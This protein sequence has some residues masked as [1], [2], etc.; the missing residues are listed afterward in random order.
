MNPTQNQDNQVPDTRPTGQDGIP[1]AGFEVWLRQ[2]AE[3]VSGPVAIEPEPF[4][5]A[6]AEVG[7]TV[8]YAGLRALAQAVAAAP[9][10]VAQVL[11][12]AALYLERH[13]WTQHV[14]YDPTATIFTPAADMVGAIAMVC[15]GGPCE[16]PAQ[17]FD[18]PG[19]LDFEQAVLH[20]D[21]FLLVEYGSQAYEFND[22]PGRRAEDVTAVLRKAATVPVHELMNALRVADAA[23]VRLAD[24]IG[25][26]AG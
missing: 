12:S 7:Y 6:V 5:G 2:V 21:R 20:L 23:D 22:A 13:G 25:G 15:Y 11:T 3:A 10:P 19:F 8:T 17:H 1:A 14:Y 9:D 18:D 4:P 26:G 24:L 16:A